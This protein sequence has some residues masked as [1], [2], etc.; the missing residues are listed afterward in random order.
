[1]AVVLA[2][3][4]GR[5]LRPLT[6]LRPKALCPVANRPLVDH[7]V[8]RARALTS[9]VAVNVHHGRDALER[10]LAGDARVH[11]SV[12]EPEAL[13]TAGALGAL[14]PWID[15][16]GV[17]VQNADTWSD[18]D[19]VAFADGWDGERVRLLVTP[20]TDGQVRFGPAVGLVAS[21]LPWAEVVGLAPVPSGLYEVMWRRAEAD[22][23]LDVVAHSGSFVDCGT[24]RQY[25]R[26]NRLAA[27]AN[28]G[29]D[30][31]GSLVD[32]SAEMIGT[33][34]RAVVGPGASVAGTVIGSVVWDGAA[35]APDE[36]LV[37][38]VRA[39][40]LTVAVR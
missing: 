30:G 35:V 3:G 15:G 9:A 20:G 16:R 34:D 38:S 2:A 22:G 21:L 17:L 8:G 13:G 25:L 11:V 4:A 12:E 14:V 37:D 24:V 1:V 6:A 40:R 5:R 27:A 28:I 31:S 33:V 23:R 26:A 10:H 19:L 29:C 36:V 39:G 18:A 32:A 7:A